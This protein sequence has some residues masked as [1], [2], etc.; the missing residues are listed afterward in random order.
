MND[1]SCPKG[2]VVKT[3]CFDTTVFKMHFSTSSSFIGLKVQFSVFIAYMMMIKTKLV[4]FTLYFCLKLMLLL[5]LL[6][7]CP[8]CCRGTALKHRK[9]E[10]KLQDNT[11]ILENICSISIFLIVCIVPYLLKIICIKTQ[12]LNVTRVAT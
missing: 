8:L 6:L 12:Y 11:E 5:L 9:T 4:H 3:G 2:I 7:T 1:M 10:D